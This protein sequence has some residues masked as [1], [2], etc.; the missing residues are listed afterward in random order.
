MIPRLQAY[1]VIGSN[2]ETTSGKYMKFHSVGL[3]NHRMEHIHTDTQVLV[4]YLVR[5]RVIFR[6][7][8][9]KFDL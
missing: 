6:S 1:K 8:Y 9:F 4:K 2:H 7:E 3:W 5:N